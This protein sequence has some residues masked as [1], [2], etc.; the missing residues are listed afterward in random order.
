MSMMKFAEKHQERGQIFCLAEMLEEGNYPFYFNFFDDL[1]PEPFTHE[2][3]DPET[4]IDWEKYNFLIQ[5]GAMVG[6]GL[7]E[8]SVC[9]NHEGDKTLLELLDMRQASIKENPTA[10]DGELICDLLAEQCMEIIEK[11]F[12]CQE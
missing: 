12:E 10:D 11:Y 8:I 7:S 5:I 4:D 9:F 1:R 6:D 3:S 2:E